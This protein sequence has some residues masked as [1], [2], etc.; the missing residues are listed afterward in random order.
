MSENEQ[1]DW[2]YRCDVTCRWLERVARD[3]DG[4]EAVREG[5]VRGESLAFGELEL[6]DER[7]EKHDRVRRARVHEKDA[8]TERVENTEQVC[9]RVETQCDVENGAE[10]KEWFCQPVEK[11]FRR[12]LSSLT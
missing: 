9:V 2:R 5:G 1:C 10:E 8:Q 12:R 11:C 4:E 7:N 6:A 3:D